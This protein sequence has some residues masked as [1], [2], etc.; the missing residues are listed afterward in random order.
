MRS[1]A[2]KTAVHGRSLPAITSLP[3]AAVQ[4]MRDSGKLGAGGTT[5]RCA[6]PD[7][8]MATAKASNENRDDRAIEVERAGICQGVELA[9]VSALI[10]SAK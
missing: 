7:R 9:V 3:M 5:S 6:Q 2:T 1:G 4:G 10:L 8:A